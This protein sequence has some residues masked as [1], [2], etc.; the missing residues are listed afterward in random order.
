MAWQLAIALA[1]GVGAAVVAGAAGEG[2]ALKERGRWTEA[3]VVDKEDAR[4]DWCTLRKPDG[5]KIAPRLTE[6]N[7]CR[8]VQ[9]GDLLRV[10]YDPQ[11][12]AAPVTS[13]GRTS[14]DSA[15]A[16]LAAVSIAMGTWGCTQ[17]SRRNE[18]HTEAE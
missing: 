16:G 18:Q 15:S 17:M 5:G 1:A 6:A 7:G 3:V 12:V 10:E 11:G 4:T 2:A 14:Y 9:P 8:W 13:A